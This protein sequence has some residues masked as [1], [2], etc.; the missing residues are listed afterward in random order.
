[1]RQL[2][3]DRSVAE[4]FCA[5]GGGRALVVLGVHVDV[6]GEHGPHRVQVTGVDRGDQQ[7]RAP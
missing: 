1:M 6:Q 2:L 3:R 4:Q 7:G 5:S